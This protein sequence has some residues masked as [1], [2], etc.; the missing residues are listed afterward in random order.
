MTA[1]LA[2]FFRTKVGVYVRQ[3]LVI[4]TMNLLLL[5]MSFLQCS[6]VGLL[7]FLTCLSRRP[8]SLTNPV[9]QYDLISPQPILISSSSSHSLPALYSSYSFPLLL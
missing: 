7:D 4:M 6:Q 8:P 1:G 2:R 9:D 3:A 5:K